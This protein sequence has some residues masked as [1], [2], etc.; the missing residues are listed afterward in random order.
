MSHCFR[1]KGQAGT[2]AKKGGASDEI[3]HSRGGA[4]TKNYAV[5]DAYNYPV[6]LMISEWQRNDINYAVP[7]LEHVNMEGSGVL[8]DRGYDSRKLIDY[9]YK[10]GGKPIVPSRKAPNSRGAV[11]G[12]SKERHLIEN[13]SKIENI[14]PDCHLL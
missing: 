4:S 7:M 2:A 13:F 3:G 10:R 9:V 1:Q 14:P 8:A 5:M 11:T 6:Y 12:G